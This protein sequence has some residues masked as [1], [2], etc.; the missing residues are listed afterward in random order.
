MSRVPVASPSCGSL[1][2]AGAAERR[3]RRDRRAA[4]VREIGTPVVLATL[5]LLGVSGCATGG[6]ADPAAA[7]PIALATEQIDVTLF[8]IGD[9]GAP[10]APADSEPVLEALRAAAARSPH[11]VIAFLGDNVYPRGMPDSGAPARPEAERRLSG[12]LAVVR[13]TGARGIFVPGNHD[14]NRQSAGGW[15]AVRREERFIAAAGGGRATLL[16]AGACPGPAVVDVGTTVRLVAMNTQWWLEDGARRED[17]AAPCARRASGFMRL[18]LLHDGR[19]RLVVMVVDR[20]GHATE[21]FALWLL[22][23]A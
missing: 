1:G 15:A 16:P 22:G 2:R 4:R 11:P 18:E 13:A 12:Q 9:A 3:R 19:A 14:W 20:R 23:T 6:R 5:L 10:A 17:P 7:A 8:L 21:E